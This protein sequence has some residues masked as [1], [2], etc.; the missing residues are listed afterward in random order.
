MVEFTNAGNTGGYI[1]PD[2]AAP[3]F[4]PHFA[5]EGFFPVESPATFDPQPV[6]DDEPDDA[7]VARLIQAAEP[8]P[9]IVE[10]S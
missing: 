8:Q 6:F 1:V 10:A 2:D 5:A 9:I 4:A 3:I 7:F